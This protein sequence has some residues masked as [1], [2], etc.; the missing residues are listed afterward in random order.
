MIH[1]PMD[2]MLIDLVARSL[3]FSEANIMFGWQGWA[4]KQAS[5]WRGLHDTWVAMSDDE[6]D[7]WKIR[8]NKI[9]AIVDPNL[10]KIITDGFIPSNE[11]WWS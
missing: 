5:E 4:Y 1:I 11:R 2:E 9:L 3:Y 10:Y 7:K 6:K 8:A